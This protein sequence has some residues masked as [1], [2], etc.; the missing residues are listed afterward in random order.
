MFTCSYWLSVGAPPICPI[1]LFLIHLP[2]SFFSN[3]HDIIAFFRRYCRLDRPHWC[4]FGLR[5]RNNFFMV[6]SLISIAIRGVHYEK[7]CF[8]V[9]YIGYKNDLGGRSFNAMPNTNSTKYYSYLAFAIVATIITFCV[10]TII[11]VL[12]K[13]IQLVVRLFKEAGKAVAAMPLL[14][15]QPLLVSTPINSTARFKNS[16]RFLRHF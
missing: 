16:V 12:R 1:Q 10:I 5:N 14:I 8:R 2:F 9:L 4:K 6:R 11:I 13:R 7:N 3:H 15:F